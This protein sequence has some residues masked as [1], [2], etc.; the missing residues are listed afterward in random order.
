MPSGGE[1]RKALMKTMLKV[2]VPA[3]RIT[4]NIKKNYPN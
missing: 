1:L 4:A 3:E 2:P